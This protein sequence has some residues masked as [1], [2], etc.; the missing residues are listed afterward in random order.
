LHYDHEFARQHDPVRFGE[1]P[2]GYFVLNT[3][4]CLQKL[5]FRK[6]AF[7]PEMLTYAE[8]IKA[9][10]AVGEYA[11]EG[12]SPLSP[13]AEFRGPIQVSPEQTSSFWA[14]HTHSREKRANGCTRMQF[15]NGEFD[16]FIC[17]GDCR[18]VYNGEA[19]EG[20]F[21]AASNIT[22]YL[23]PNTGHALTLASNAS[24]G[25]EIML[26]YLDSQGL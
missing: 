24:A 2:S 4:S 13:A 22:T 8:R 11:S 18:N 25:Y 12:T 5:F 14:S 19:T 3:E 1:Y 10:E 7:K 26:Q 16:N 20:L 9:P 17:V 23:Q 15:F 6:G 21:P